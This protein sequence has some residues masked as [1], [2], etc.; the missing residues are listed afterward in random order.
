[1]RFKA[2]RAQGLTLPWAVRKTPIQSMTA[3]DKKCPGKEDCSS[4]FTDNL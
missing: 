2:N 4:A 3:T 1:M